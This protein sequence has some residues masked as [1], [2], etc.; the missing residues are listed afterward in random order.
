MQKGCGRGTTRKREKEWRYRPRAQKGDETIR[1]RWKGAGGSRKKLK[2]QGLGSKK[3][4]SEVEKIRNS[5]FE[6]PILHLPS[7]ISEGSYLL[8]PICYLLTGKA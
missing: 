5:N 8:T 7:P 6:M 3:L 4:G 2:I 1:G